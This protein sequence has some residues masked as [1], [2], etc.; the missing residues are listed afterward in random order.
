MES[1]GP[2]MEEKWNAVEPRTGRSCATFG[3]KQDA[4]KVSQSVQNWLFMCHF[5]QAK[6]HSSFSRNCP[7]FVP[8]K[9]RAG[10]DK[11]FALVCVSILL[12]DGNN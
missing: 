12:S 6:Q 3:W 1:G 10:Y 11:L 7:P 9:N 2:T 8:V 4:A 5:V